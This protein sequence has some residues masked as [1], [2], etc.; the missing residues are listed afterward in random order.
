MGERDPV[1]RSG[2]FASC[3]EVIGKTRARAIVAYLADAPATAHDLAEEFGVSDKTIYGALSTLEHQGDVKRSGGV[4]R[5][6][7]RGPL[8]SIWKATEK[9]RNGHVRR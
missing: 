2:A 8:C 7:F 9:G 5:Y 6:G 3:A 1:V 4:I